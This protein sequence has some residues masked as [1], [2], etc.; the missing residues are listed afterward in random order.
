MNSKR[1]RQAD[2]N[3]IQTLQLHRVHSPLSKT[4]IRWHC[5]DLYREYHD[6]GHKMVFSFSDFQRS[7]TKEI[8]EI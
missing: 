5:F 4:V 1:T 3:D 2:S 6:S 8:D 7:K